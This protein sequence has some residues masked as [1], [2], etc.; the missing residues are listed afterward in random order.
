MP[1]EWSKWYIDQWNSKLL[2][3][4]VDVQVCLEKNVC[5]ILKEP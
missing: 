3:V 2:N 5:L 4:F 1:K